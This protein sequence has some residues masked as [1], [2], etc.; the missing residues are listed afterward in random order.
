MKCTFCGSES[1]VLDTP[2]I[3]RVTGEAK[4]TFCCNPQKRNAE[5][6]ANHYHPIYADKPPREEDERL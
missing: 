2:Y 4:K 5:Y 6:R 3:D 1:T